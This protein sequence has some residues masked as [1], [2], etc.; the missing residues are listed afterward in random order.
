MVCFNSIIL[1]TSIVWKKVL[2][3][4]RALYHPPT[5]TS[6]HP[7]CYTPSLR[8]AFNDGD[9]V[10]MV[11]GLVEFEARGGFLDSSYEEFRCPFGILWVKRSR[12]LE[13]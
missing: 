4:K 13:V 1:F 9:A 5:E 10:P 8:L 12:V 11:T 2:S 6:L 7:S 3:P